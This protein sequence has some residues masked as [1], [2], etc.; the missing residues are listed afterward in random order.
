MPPPFAGLKQVKR[1]I[2][3]P[4]TLESSSDSRSPTPPPEPKRLKKSAKVA[5]KKK[6]AAKRPEPDNSDLDDGSA[7]QSPEPSE[8]RTHIATKR[9][10]EDDAPHDRHVIAAYRALDHRAQFITRAAQNYE[11]LYE[12]ARILPRLIGTFVN[13]DRVLTAGLA[14]E[15]KY[16]ADDPER[17]ELIFGDYYE[18]FCYFSI[19]CTNFPGFE[20]HTDYLRQHHD[21]VVRLAKFMHTVA[22]KARSDDANRVKMHIYEVAQWGDIDKNLSR[23]TARGFKHVYT[24]RLLCPVSQLADFDADPERFCRA[25]RDLHDAG[26][27]VTGEDWPMFMYDMDEYDPEDYKAGFLKG[28]LLLQCFKIVFTGPSSALPAEGRGKPKGKPP[29]IRTFDDPSG[30]ISF[31][32]VV[33]I[34]CIARFVLNAQPEWSD[35]DGDF[36]GLDFVRSVLTVALQ[37]PEWKDDII[38][39]YIKNVVDEPRGRGPPPGRRTTYSAIL[40]G[41]RAAQ[42]PKSASTASGKRRADD[43]HHSANEDDAVGDDNDVSEPPA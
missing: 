28:R 23:K 20:E 26:P 39:W 6:K 31:F 7:P 22:G 29:V 40:A 8:N 13:Y 4:S 42:G 1:K 34:A 19:I 33:Y 16:S 9:Q 35:D 36:R 11:H 21:L 27:W 41:K 5:E 37:Y 18:V 3:L 15:G 10:R 32:A 25:I 24:G 17:E 38:D 30:S 12:A 43:S 14:R 2:P